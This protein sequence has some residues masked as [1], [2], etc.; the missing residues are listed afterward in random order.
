M[1]TTNGILVIWHHQGG[2]NSTGK[3]AFHGQAGAPRHPRHVIHCVGW[4]KPAI[5]AS[6]FLDFYSD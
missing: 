1:E 3:E 5:Q 4:L 2:F 6:S